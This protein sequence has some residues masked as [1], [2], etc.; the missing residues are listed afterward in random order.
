MDDEQDA[1]LDNEETKDLADTAQ[2]VEESVRDEG[3]D[4][5]AVTI[6]AIDSKLDQVIAALGELTAKVDGLPTF[7]GALEEGAVFRDD[8]ADVTEVA[9]PTS[10]LSDLDLSI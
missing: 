3:R 4:E 9:L 6:A 10:D 8:D 1:R 7:E 5:A 2:R